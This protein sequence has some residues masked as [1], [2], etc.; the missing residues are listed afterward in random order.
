MRDTS[1][2]TIASSVSAVRTV[3]LVLFSLASLLRAQSL[4]KLPLLR[5]LELRGRTFHVQGIETGGNR[6][7]V[8]SVDRPTQT[9]YL[10]EFDSTTGQL[11]RE[12]RLQDGLRFH[13]GGIAGTGDALWIPIAEYRAKS[14]SI[15]QRRNKRTLAVEAQFAVDDHIGCIAVH[16][17]GLIGGNWDTKEL[18]F[19][20]NKGKLIRKEA[21]PVRNA[22]QDIK[23][24]AGMLVGS[25]LLPDGS[26]AI[27]WLDPVSLKPTRHL[28]VGKTDRG[29]VFT[30]EGMTIQGDE[31][32]LLPED[33]HSRLFVF[34]LTNR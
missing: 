30:R 23:V 2:T 33:E 24:A 14:T 17:S 11:I 29:N 32:M 19:W 21:N 12:V 20:D 16:D 31:L 13:P 18:Y 6:L 7:W 26:G 5:V 15:I 22:F 28:S 8:T 34:R 9:G 1:S 27:D 25:G 10:H 4:D 3:L